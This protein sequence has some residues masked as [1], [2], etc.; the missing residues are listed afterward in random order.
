MSLLNQGYEFLGDDLILID[1]HEDRVYPYPRPLH[2]FTYNVRSLDGAKLPV[3]VTIA[4]YFKNLVR[5][6]LEKILKTDFLISTRVHVD[7]IIRGI[8][9]SSPG[10]ISNIIF[11]KK[12][13]HHESISL[14]SSQIMEEHARNIVES[15]DLNLSLYRFLDRTT[16]QEVQQ[17]E[18][19]VTQSMLEKAK[20]F[21]YLN[22][23]KIDLAEI[24]RYLNDV[25][26]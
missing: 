25:E 6:V 19:Q 20:Y 14:D 3:G 11:L 9:F 2:I 16:V 4:V 12:K 1:P 18:L 24:T 26:A 13:G 22:T 23:R 15:A 5:Y 10:S 17:Q 21:G 8:R 7:E